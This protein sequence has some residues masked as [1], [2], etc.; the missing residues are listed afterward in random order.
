M[1]VSSAA[2][3]H[4]SSCNSRAPE[5]CCSAFCSWS[6]RVVGAECEASHSLSRAFL[7]RPQIE[8]ALGQTSSR[9]VEVVECVECVGRRVCTGVP[10]R[11]GRDA[12]RVWFT[13]PLPP[14][15]STLHPP[16]YILHPT[17]YTHK[18]PY[19]LHPTLYTHKTRERAVR[20]A[21]ASSS[22]LAASSIS[23]AETPSL[24]SRAFLSA[25]SAPCT[26]ANA[27]WV[28]QALG[29]R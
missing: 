14:T 12:S 29:E 10:Q 8:C 2:A 26:S 9:R 20:T 6:R 11:R 17:L 4:F 13:Y 28:G 22:S 3:F 24:S 16:P 23:R 7:A 15:P 19:T 25:S 5:S 21:R 27:C 1:G 18:T